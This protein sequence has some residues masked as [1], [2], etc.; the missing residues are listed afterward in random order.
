MSAVF[1]GTVVKCWSQLAA[2]H[3]AVVSSKPTRNVRNF[4]NRG[5]KCNIKKMQNKVQNMIC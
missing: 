5:K 1:R 4:S 3:P 2:N